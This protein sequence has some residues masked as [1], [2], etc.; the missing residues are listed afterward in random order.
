MSLTSHFITLMT[1]FRTCATRHWARD[2]NYTLW[3]RP[4]LCNRWSHKLVPW[5]TLVCMVSVMKSVA[6]LL[7][8]VKRVSLQASSK[9]QIWYNRP[10]ACIL[11]VSSTENMCSRSAPKEWRLKDYDI[12]VPSNCSRERLR[13]YH[14]PIGQ[15]LPLYH[16][17]L[18]DEHLACQIEESCRPQA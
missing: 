12:T 6:V 18:F 7:V 16:L 4:P 13:L 8:P 3:Q 14:S 5:G 9:G 10:S 15:R 1:F 11:L 17:E 2:F